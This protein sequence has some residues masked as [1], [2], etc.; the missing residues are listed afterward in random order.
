MLETGVVQVSDNHSIRIEGRDIF[1]VFFN[2]KV[3]CGFS[4]ESP[5]RGNFNEN[6]KYTI[7]NTKKRKSF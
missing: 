5:H 6:T 2:M 4:L 3:Y 1:L 7:F